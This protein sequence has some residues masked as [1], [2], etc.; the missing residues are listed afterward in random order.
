[1]GPIGRQSTS[2]AISH[3][4][5]FDRYAISPIVTLHNS[6]VGIVTIGG[7][8]TLGP[9][10]RAARDPLGRD[11]Y[12]GI[13]QW[14]LWMMLGWNDIRR[15]YR[16]SYLG[17]FWVTISMGLLVAALGSLYAHIFRTDMDT[18]VPYLA[19]GF[20]VWGLISSCVKESC[21]AFWVQANMIKQIKVPF[22]VHVLRVVWANLIV[23]LHT[24]IIF[25]PISLYFRHWLQ[26][27]AL[28]ALPGIL[29]LSLNLVWV[30]LFLAVF[31]ARFRDVS[32]M[33][34]TL[35]QIAV[36][37]T[38]IMWPVSA[39]GARGFVADL[40]PIYHLIELVRAP[41]LGHAPAILSWI[42][43]FAAAA[44]GLLLSAFLL[45]R[46]ERRIVYWL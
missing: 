44:F 18:Y 1:M 3:V 31:N 16:R 17:P 4:H 36:F 43:T 40:N 24:I 19:L 35:L 21:N 42:V 10:I 12:D 22:S 13:A 11:L 2:G 25:V 26:P 46:V 33:V 41:L 34:E 14:R 38:P 30:G 39:L 8:G 32:L 7:T 45:R 37:A 9:R 27:V 5:H 29:I 6:T 20:I 23:L 28:L 15:R